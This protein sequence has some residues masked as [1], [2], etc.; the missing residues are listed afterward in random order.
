M[1][2][3]N[4]DTI[5]SRTDGTPQLDRGAEVTVGMAITGAGGINVSG[6]CTATEFS[7]RVTGNVTGN[8]SGTA[9]GL[10]GTPDVSV[11]NVTAGFGTF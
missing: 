6:Y 7:G 8:T 5:R 9:G 1:S 4:V 11:N 2:Q 10:S 3:I